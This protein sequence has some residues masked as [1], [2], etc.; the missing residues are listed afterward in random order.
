MPS[1]VTDL[2]VAGFAGGDHVPRVVA[3]DGPAEGVVDDGGDGGADVG[4]L[5]AAAV[6]IA[7]EDL[8]TDLAA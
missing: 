3:G 8:G 2:L 1:R 7:H 6:A 5:D 4:E